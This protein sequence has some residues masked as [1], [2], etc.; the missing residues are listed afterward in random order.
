[1]P[2]KVTDFLKGYLLYNTAEL[3]R[4]Q[5]GLVFFPRFYKSLHGEFILRSVFLALV[6]SRGRNRH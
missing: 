5:I 4:K 6:S 3:Q 1:M 2:T